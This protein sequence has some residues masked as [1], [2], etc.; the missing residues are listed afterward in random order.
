MTLQ[1]LI[2]NLLL[3]LIA[4]IAINSKLLQFYFNQVKSELCC[5]NFT[6]NWCR[7]LTLVDVVDFCS[8][9]HLYSKR[10]TSTNH[11]ESYCL[12]QKGNGEVQDLTLLTILIQKKLSISQ[13]CF[14]TLKFISHTKRQWLFSKGRVQKKSIME[15]SILGGGQ[16]GSFSISNFIFFAPNGLKIIFRHWS[17]FYV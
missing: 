4:T 15:N 12:G 1:I 14:I 16:R 17:F 13:N 3:T 11:F 5:W 9:T 7:I 2:W 6:V 8:A 10:K